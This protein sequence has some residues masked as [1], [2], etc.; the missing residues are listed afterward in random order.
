MSSARAQSRAEAN[1]GPKRPPV[2]FDAFA[3]TYQDYLNHS[4]RI[5]GDT[6]DY[7][8]AYKAAFIARNLAPSGGK[9]LDYGCGIGLLAGHLKRS[10]PNVQIDGFDISQDCVD[11]IDTSLAQQGVFTSDLQQSA[12]SY[13]VV[14]LSNVLHHVKPQDRLPLLQGIKSRL[15]ENGKLVVFEHNP[16][17]LLTRWAVSQCVFD[18]DAILLSRGDMFRCMREAGL[19]ILR[20]DYIVFFPRYFAWLRPLEPFLRWCPFG[21]QR[22]VVVGRDSAR[23]SREQL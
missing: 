2:E 6:S 3:S 21:A 10:L 15:A 9:V 4:V 22:V 11:Q 13:D 18:Q 17:N 23:A 20:H 5:S 12:R 19:R 1:R 8:A 16:I 14:V 7:F